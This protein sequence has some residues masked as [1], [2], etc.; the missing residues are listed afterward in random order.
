MAATGTPTLTLLQ[1]DNQIKVAQ[2]M[3]EAGTIINLGFGDKVAGAEI[4][5]ELKRLTNDFQTRKEMSIKGQ[6]LI[7]GH[8]AERTADYILHS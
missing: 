8:G 3:A 4:S 1:A 6:N 2:A 7:D 5:A